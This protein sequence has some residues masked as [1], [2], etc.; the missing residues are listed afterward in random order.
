M[1]KLVKVEGAKQD[2]VWV[3]V[4]KSFVDSLPPKFAHWE[5]PVCTSAKF[6]IGCFGSAVRVGC[7][8]CA[9]EIEI[10][11]ENMGSASLVIPV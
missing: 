3:K 2:Q 11:Y 1:S 5:C 10:K 8:K 4:D 7:A 9:W 6:M